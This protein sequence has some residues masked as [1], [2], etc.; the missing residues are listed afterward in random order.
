MDCTQNI[1]IEN[2]TLSLDGLSMGEL[3]DLKLGYEWGSSEYVQI[4]NRMPNFCQADLSH[5]LI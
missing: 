1:N 5:N 3:N 4:E 2:N